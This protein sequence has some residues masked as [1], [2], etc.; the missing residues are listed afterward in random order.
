MA[1]AVRDRATQPLDRDAASDDMSPDDAAIAGDVRSK[2]AAAV[3]SL[4]L[5]Q[6]DVIVLCLEDL[7]IQEIAVSLGITRNAAAQRCQRAKSALREMLDG[8]VRER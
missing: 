4:P 2:V 6:R 5:P 7:S 1:R 3:Q 8:M